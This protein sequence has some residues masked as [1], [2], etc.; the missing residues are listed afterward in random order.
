VRDALVV[1]AS[2][3]LPTRLS[4]TWSS[5]HPAAAEAHSCLVSP[6]AAAAAPVLRLPAS[7]LLGNADYRRTGRP[8]HGIATMPGLPGIKLSNRR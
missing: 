2:Q 8:P 5:H 6:A 4:T 7:F 1:H 3:V